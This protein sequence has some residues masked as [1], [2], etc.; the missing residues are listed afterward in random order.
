MPSDIAPRAGLR[1]WI[2]LVTL[3]CPALLIGLDFT[4]LH[5]VLPHLAA[6]LNP[7]SVE[8]LWIV[9]IYGFVIAGLLIPMGALGDRIGRRRMLLIGSVLFALAS[10]LTAY[11]N[12]PEM[13]IATRALLGLTGATLL[14]S[15]LSLITN[16]F[17]DDN[18]RRLAIAVWSTAFSIGNAAGPV[19]G[20]AMLEHFWW[21]SVFLLALPV[22]LALM[23]LSPFVVPEYRDAEASGRIDMTSVAL[24]LA[25][26]LTIVYG[27]KEIAKDGLG[28]VPVAAIVVG[29][30]VG[31]VFLRR[32]RKLPDPLLDLV[33]FTRRAFTVSIGAQMLVLFTL[34][35][36]QF[37]LMQYLQLV[38]GLSPLTAGLWTLPGM[39]AGVVGA[40]LG[41]VFTRKYTPHQVIT[42]GLVVATVGLV[43][44]VW[45]V[46]ALLPTVVAF[47]V[48]NLAINIVWALSYDQILSAAPPERAGTA[49]GAAETGNE[50][51]IALGVALSG[52]LGA[53]VYHASV[54][55]SL[56]AGLS[57]E[58]ADAAADTLTGATAVAERVPRELADQVLE[59]TR[60][61][62]TNSMQL[63][64]GVLA[65][66]MAG[67]A[68]AVGRLLRNRS[69]DG[70][71]A[72]D[73]T[74]TE[75]PAG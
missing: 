49:S 54:A 60:D 6:E 59:V 31:A 9:D 14:P 5:L 43:G 50:L 64:T 24:L 56:P 71:P 26:L 8:M 53:A 29:L 25:S 41:P 61:A 34:A 72:Q 63:T 1:E 40:L 17:R 75:Q 52:S 4:V 74:A 20:G 22:M 3:T 47:V 46:Q 28:L 21:G 62:F 51:G 38:L 30:A 12:S 10:V 36:F 45:A 37:F 55:D 7:S 33:L 69:R 15:T 65:V 18:Q 23:V 48:M 32:Q 58:D 44:A 70:E 39:L 68:L 35:A 11:A 73:D 57:P 67:M 19:V 66:L 16:M 27:I 2:G 42:G 13:V